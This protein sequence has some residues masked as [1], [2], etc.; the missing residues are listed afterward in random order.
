MGGCIFS[1]FNMNLSVL[2]R[3]WRFWLAVVILGGVMACSSIIIFG[4]ALSDLGQQPTREA[5]Q[6]MTIFRDTCGSGGGVA[7]APGLT[8][9]TG[10]HQV[11]VYRSLLPSTGDL[12]SYYNRTEDLPEEWRATLPNETELVACVHAERVVIE[13][14]EYT[15][16]SGATGVLR[17]EQWL[18]RIVLH[19]AHS[20]DV[21][22]QETLQGER[23]RECQDTETFTEGT[24]SLQV[25]GTQVAP[26]AIADWLESRVAP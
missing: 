21:I 26:K 6:A 15:L 14:C 22:E 9:P 11:V 2:I 1:E 10:P 12:S 23:P 13:E 3:D 4:T 19:D 7:E 16:E 17:R 25:E 20:G 8:S 18:A 5:L 24:L